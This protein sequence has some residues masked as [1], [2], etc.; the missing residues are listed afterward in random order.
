[1]IRKKVFIKTNTYIGKDYY[2]KILVTSDDMMINIISY[3]FA[4]N[5]SNIN[6]PGYLSY[7]TFY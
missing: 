1:M 6:L 4:N 3:Q 2:N 7:L 5:Y